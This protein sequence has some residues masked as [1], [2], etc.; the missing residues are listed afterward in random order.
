MTLI[1]IRERSGSNG[2][3]ATVSF[4]GQGE[5]LVTISLPFSDEEEERLEWYFERHLR[6]PFV[7]RAGSPA[8]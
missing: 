6:L 1:S 8:G 7:E 4:D 5:Y 2:A 3:N